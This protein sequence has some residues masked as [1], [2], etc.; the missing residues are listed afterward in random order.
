MKQDGGK[1]IVEAMRDDTTSE[2]F[3]EVKNDGKN[4]VLLQKLVKK[5]EGQEG[6]RVAQLRRLLQTNER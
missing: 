2:R 6:A 3:R 5:F 4:A 1:K